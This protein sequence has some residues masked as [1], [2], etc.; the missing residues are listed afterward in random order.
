MTENRSPRGFEYVAPAHRSLRPLGPRAQIEAAMAYIQRRYGQRYDEDD[1]RRHSEAA[2]LESGAEATEKPV[3]RADA[4]R[5][6]TQKRG[7][8]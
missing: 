5:G 1:E 8:A 4:F 2:G 6:A 7:E 3:S